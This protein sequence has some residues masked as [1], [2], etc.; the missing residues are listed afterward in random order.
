MTFSNGCKQGLLVRLFIALI[1]LPALLSGCFFFQDQIKTKHFVE[2]CSSEDQHRYIQSLQTWDASGKASLRV[3]KEANTLYLNWKGDHQGGFTLRL[4]GFLGQGAVTLS[5][6]FHDA[7]SVIKT[8]DETFEAE[9]PEYAIYQAT[10]LIL[11]IQTLKNWLLFSDSST[12]SQLSPDGQWRASFKKWQNVDGL[13]LPKTLS[14]KHT[15]NSIQLKIVITD[16]ELIHPTHTS[17]PCL[18]SH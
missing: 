17:T 14:I 6:E 5:R 2:I 16:W 18:A 11:P 10:G 1:C 3:E 4:S 9:T 12:P 13:T 15:S 8:P 7:P